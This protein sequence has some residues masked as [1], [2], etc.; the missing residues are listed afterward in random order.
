MSNENESQRVFQQTV[1]T[2]ESFIAPKC[3]GLGKENFIGRFP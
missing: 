3:E 2:F 1:A